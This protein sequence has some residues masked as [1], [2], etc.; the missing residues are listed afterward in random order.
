MKTETTTVAVQRLVDGR[1][2]FVWTG[3]D[4]GTFVSEELTSSVRSYFNAAKGVKSLFGKIKFV[5]YPDSKVC[6]HDSHQ[7]FLRHWDVSVDD[8]LVADAFMR[9][10]WGSIMR[11][12]NVR[13]NNS[14]KAIQSLMNSEYEM[15][16]GY[17]G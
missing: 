3:K 15:G 5:A 6:C 11:A 14:P 4:A 17:F 9:T 13:C 7:Y 2:V 1:L 16:S 10:Y 8:K 12:L